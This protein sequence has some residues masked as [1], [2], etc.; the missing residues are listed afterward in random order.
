MANQAKFRI[1]NPGI[2]WSLQTIENFGRYT[3][4]A[5]YM[6]E[7]DDVYVD[8]KNRRLF[9]AGYCCRKRNQ[10][11]GFLITLIK[12]RS[13]KGAS[14]K[15]GKWHVLLKKNKN[16]PEDW[17]KSE[18]RTRVLKVVSNKKLHSTLTL[19]QT[20][21]ARSIKKKDQVIALA[22]LDDVSIIENGKNQQFKRLKIKMH[23][24]GGE[25]QLKSIIASLQEKWSLKPEA[26]IKFERS[27][28]IERKT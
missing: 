23:I 5:P 15:T 16:D 14:K 8:T 26:L 1:T 3:L 2:Y 6:E 21:I 12:L 4:S 11:R 9:A 19:H 24:Q 27:L 25:D 18:V 13:A 7:L 10:S 22:T 17:P 28:A 20:R